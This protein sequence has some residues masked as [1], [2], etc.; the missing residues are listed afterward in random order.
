MEDRFEMVLEAV[1]RAFLGVY[2]LLHG[3]PSQKKVFFGGLE[4]CLLATLLSVSI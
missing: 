1:G 4:W 3:R 2:G